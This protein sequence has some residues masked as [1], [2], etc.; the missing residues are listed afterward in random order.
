ML[1]SLKVESHT[2][3]KIIMNMGSAVSKPIAD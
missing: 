3:L 1:R 2:K